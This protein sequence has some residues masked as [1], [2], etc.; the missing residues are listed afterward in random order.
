[1]ELLR[2]QVI[3]VVE[4]L[5]LFSMYLYIKEC[6]HSFPEQTAIEDVLNLY[7]VVIVSLKKV[8]VLIAILV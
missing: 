1:M 3:E 2:S 7:Q 5:Q 8:I 6:V 4:N